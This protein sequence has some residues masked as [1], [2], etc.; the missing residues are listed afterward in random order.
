M[1]Y[2]LIHIQNM[3]QQSK[4]MRE[5]HA[6][7]RDVR[8]RSETIETLL[9]LIYYQVTMYERDLEDIT[10]EEAIPKQDITMIQMRLQHI[11]TVISTAL[12]E[13]PRTI[14]KTSDI[15]KK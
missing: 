1:I 5:L 4:E 7:I 15:E 2:Q 10:I 8:H 13:N 3:P 12:S 6:Q 9:N 11:I 14:K